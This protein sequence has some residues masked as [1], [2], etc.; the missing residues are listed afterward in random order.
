M[1]WKSGHGN[2]L[3][4]ASLPLEVERLCQRSVNGISGN[5]SATLPV[6]SVVDTQIAGDDEDSVLATR[7]EDS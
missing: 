5:V 2:K 7:G 1:T 3:F 6:L 4:R